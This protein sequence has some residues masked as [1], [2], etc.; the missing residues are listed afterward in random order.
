MTIETLA[1][2]NE[3]QVSADAITD[4]PGGEGHVPTV[5]TKTGGAKGDP[6]ECRR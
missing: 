3:C 4:C 1:C 2:W 5:I 6:G